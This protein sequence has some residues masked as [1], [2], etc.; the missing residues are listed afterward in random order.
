[1]AD[2]VKRP[3]A[4]A[5]LCAVALGLLTLL[6]YGSAGFRELDAET[7]VRLSSHRESRPGEWAEAL[8]LMAD[9]IPLL[10]L[11]LAAGGIGLARHRPRDALAAVVVVAGA[12]LTTQLMKAFL[13]HP[14]AQVLLGGSG[15][16]PVGFP[17]GHTTAAFSIGVAFAFVLPRELVPLTLALGLAY[18]AAV[19]CAVV[20]IAWHFPSDAVGALLVVATWGFAAL[21]GVRAVSPPKS[22]AAERGGLSPPGALPSR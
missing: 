13:A 21:A 9:P 10:L 2:D 4:A 6:V 20:V 16:H 17:S 5:L 3:V 22:R 1:M 11:L 15:Y 12:N 8:A 18:G 7:F 14:R 19:G